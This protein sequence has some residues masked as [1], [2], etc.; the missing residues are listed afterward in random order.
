MNAL[1]RF[2][3]Y[4]AD[5]EKTYADDDW[6]R[7]RP[8]FS[9]DAVYEVQSEAFGGA[10]K[11]PDAIAAGLAKSVNGFDRR[12]DQRTVELIGQPEVADDEMRVTWLVHYEKAGVEPYTLRGSTVVRFRDGRIVHMADVYDAAT[13]AELRGWQTRNDLEIDPS[14]T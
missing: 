13:D 9:D 6:S 7:I 14:Y 4:A 10:M 5:F 2:L 1:E 12:F 11:G 8:Y 3:A